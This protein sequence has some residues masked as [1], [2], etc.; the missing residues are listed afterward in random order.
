MASKRIR[1]HVVHYQDCKNLVM[2]YID[3]LTRK[4]VRSTKY[5][6]P[7]TGEETPTGSNDKFARKLAARWEADLNAGR[8]Q[9]RYATTWEQFRQRYEDEVV[10]SLADGTGHKIATTFNLVEKILPAV[11]NGK[12]TDLTAEA[13]SQFQ[14]GLRAGGRAESTIAGYLAHLKAALTWAVEM[15]LLAERPAIRKPKRAKKGGRKM[16]GRAVTAEEFDRMLG[17]VPAALAE[18]RR[19]RRDVARAAARKKGLA[20]HKTNTDSIPV[21]I[22]PAAIESWQHYLKGLWFSGLRL[23][24]SL[25]LSWDRDDRP[26]VDLT[27]E[28]PL[29][30]IPAEWQ[31]A[32]RDTQTTITPDFAK[33]LLQTLPADR[34]GPVFRPMMPGGV[35]RYDQAGKM[36]SLIGE[37]ARV[38]VHTHPKTG[39]VKFASAHDL[40]R[41]FGTRWSKVVSA[42]ELQDMMRHA[43]YHT[44]QAYYVDNQAVDLARNIWRKAGVDLGTVLGTVDDSSEDSAVSAGDSNSN[45]FK[46]L[47][48]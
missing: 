39:K 44:T 11:V 47:D 16:K 35:A 13:L 6:D 32:D 36:V 33:F 29:L 41:S 21:E 45:G 18:W 1:V 14:Q 4:P 9:G 43:D 8:D 25:N 48:E 5:R 40:R 34:R 46:G 37:L 31:K 42:S 10:T 7:Q 20:E 24:E 2:R 15:E 28:I 19:R 12:L 38:V 30:A 23:D 26:R 22:D 17:K 3:P 27:A